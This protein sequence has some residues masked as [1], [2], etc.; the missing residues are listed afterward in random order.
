MSETIRDDIKRRIRTA[1][2]VGAGGLLTCSLTANAFEFKSRGFDLSLLAGLTLLAAAVWIALRT[3]CPKCAQGIGEEIGAQVAFSSPERAP[4]FC[5]YCGVSLDLRLQE[6][7][8]RDR[9]SVLNTAPR[10][11]TT[12]QGALASAALTDGVETRPAA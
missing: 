2:S 9:V 6:D 7:G 10:G 1:A 8:E 11:G 4:R 3:T 12:G 5:P